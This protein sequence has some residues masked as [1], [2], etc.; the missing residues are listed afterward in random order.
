MSAGP[1]DKTLS[2]F[3]EVLEYTLKNGF[4]T[5]TII[6][7]I[8]VGAYAQEKNEVLFSADLDLLM[9]ADDQLQFANQSSRLPQVRVCK[10]PQA[11]T[12]GVLV[13]DWKGLEINVLT[14]SPGLPKPEMARERAWLICNYPVASPFDLLSNK[15]K[16]RRGKDLEHIELLRKVCEDL[17]FHAF[18]TEPGREA[19]RFMKQLL[20]VESSQSL[21]PK[22]MNELV[23]HA[24]DSSEQGRK[25]LLT[26]ASDPEHRQEI[27]A[28]APA[29][30]QEQLRR[31]AATQDK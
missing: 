9:S 8:A 26:I 29:G 6:G 2:D 1:R 27:I 4:E 17:A 13:L 14:Q 5:T 25:F 30:E 28:Q 31:I 21:S 23:L 12:L 3:V 11:R 24:K 18:V 10:L 15:L 19:N 20:A 22:L 7:G 16:I